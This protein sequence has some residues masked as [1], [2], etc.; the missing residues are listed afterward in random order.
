MKV[1]FFVPEGDLGKMQVGTPLEIRMDGLAGPLE[2]KVSFVSPQAE[3]TL[4]IIYSRENR[5]KLVYLVEASLGAEGARQL[6][7]GAPVEVRLKSASESG[8]LAEQVK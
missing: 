7:P 6:H 8:H 4:P 2:G 3:Y 5:G 1:R